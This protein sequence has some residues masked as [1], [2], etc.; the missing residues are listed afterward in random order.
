MTPLA[1]P[2][3]QD[4]EAAAL[5]LSAR[6]HKTPVLTSGT[7]DT[8]VDAQVFFKCEQLQRMG[9]FKIRGAFNAL[10]KLDKASR[11]RGVVAYSSGNHAQGVALAARELGMMAVIVMPSDAPSAKQAATQAYGAKVVTYDRNL[12]DRSAIAQQLQHEHGYTLIP[13][14]DHADVI[15]GQGTAALELFDQVGALDILLVP[16]GG[17]GL[18]SGAALAAQL[19]C[20]ACQVI[21]VEPVEGNDGQRSFRAGSIVTIPTPRTIADGAQTLALGKLT[22]PLIQALVSDM[23]TVSDAQLLQAMRLLAERMKLVVEPTG[24]LAAAAALTL[25]DRWRGKRVGV[26]LSGGNVDLQQYGRLLLEAADCEM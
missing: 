22:F 5:R 8:L 16:V 1:P 18:I 14:Y 9:A 17:G 21:G 6:V 2:T 11:D 12:E 25:R 3:A 23:V 10:L 7:F 24:C 19:R 15:A 20:P 4:V 13:P 26:I